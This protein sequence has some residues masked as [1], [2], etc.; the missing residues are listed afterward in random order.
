MIIECYG[1]IG[2]YGYWGDESDVSPASFIEQ[3][4]SMSID[5]NNLEIRIN[6]LGGIT[7]DGLTILNRGLAFI[8]SRKTIN[9]DFKAITYVDG[10]SY[11][12][13]TLIQM[14]GVDGIVMNPGTM[15][16]VHRAWTGM[17]GNANDFRDIANYL[18]KLDG[19]IS[20]LYARTQ[21]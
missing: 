4:D 10:F 5:D 20:Q 21:N 14:L 19:E 2:D 3:L 15:M 12:A 17:S 11:S 7:R 9:P 1:D 16:M 13:A 18:D 8:K 6:S